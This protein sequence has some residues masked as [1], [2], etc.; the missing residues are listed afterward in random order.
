M[1]FVIYI[2]AFFILSVNRV[3]GRALLSFLV[4]QRLGN[5]HE[6][7]SNKKFSNAVS[8]SF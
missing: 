8:P 3:K 5:L 6:Q 4:F 7:V 2:H 1:S